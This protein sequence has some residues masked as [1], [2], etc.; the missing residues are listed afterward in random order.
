MGLE[1]HVLDVKMHQNRWRLGLT[2]LPRPPAGF[3]PLRGCTFKYPT[4][5]GSEVE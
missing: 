5:K 4:S 2:A 3:K 1:V